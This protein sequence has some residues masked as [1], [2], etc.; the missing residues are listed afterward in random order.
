MDNPQEELLTF[1][2]LGMSCAACQHHVE[3]ALRATKGVATARVDLM[4]H[5]ASVAYDPAVVTP[6]QLIAAIRDAGYDAVL[7]RPGAASTEAGTNS[8]RA[9]IKA[10]VTIVAGVAAMVLSMPLGSTMGAFDHLLMRW[11]PWLYDLP[12]ETLRWSL[13]APTAIL[14]VWAGIGIYGSAARGLRHGTT[15]MNTLVSLGTGVAFFYSAYSTIW[16]EMM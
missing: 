9:G 3:A 8:S 15:N 7:P 4:A 12:Q 6:M 13:L 5:R 10:W 11:L 16:P 1:P 14:M 2:V